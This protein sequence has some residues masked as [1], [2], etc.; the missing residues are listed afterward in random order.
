LCDDKSQ[1]VAAVHGGWRGL[2]GGILLET[3]NQYPGKTD[4]IMAW[5]GPA[6]SQ[7]HFEVGDDVREAILALNP[8]WRDVFV[9]SNVSHKWFADLYLL[10]RYQ[11]RALGVTRVYGGNYCTYADRTRFYSFRRDGVTGRM[12]SLIWITD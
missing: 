12:A 9:P 3:L 6:I 10:A 11:L 7:A 2:A 1:W 8:L 5:L 4:S